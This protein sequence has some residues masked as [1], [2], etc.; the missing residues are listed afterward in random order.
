MK[1]F[2]MRAWNPEKESMDIVSC[3]YFLDNDIRVEALPWKDKNVSEGLVL[4][5]FTG[6]NDVYGN[7]ICE[8]DICEFELNTLVQKGEIFYFPDDAAFFIT[9]F[10]GRKLLSEVKNLR[11]VGN[12][13]QKTI[14]KREAFIVKYVED[15]NVVNT[16]HYS[17]F[18]SSKKKAVEIVSDFIRK[19]NHHK[20]INYGYTLSIV[21]DDG[22]SEVNYYVPDKLSS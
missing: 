22:I 19:Q 17:V 20:S 16:K 9:T 13:Y 4:M 2:K 8:S 5:L 21:D 12:I 15:E 18:A 3:I 6:R 10:N 14:D 11:V 1:Y 7:E